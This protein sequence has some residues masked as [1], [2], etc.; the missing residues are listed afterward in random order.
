MPLERFGAHITQI[1]HH[2]SLAC[3]CIWFICYIFPMA[4]IDVFVGLFC[5][6]CV[7]FWFLPRLRFALRGLA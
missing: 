6:P 7:G 5:A 2:L 1:H 3:I 4:Y